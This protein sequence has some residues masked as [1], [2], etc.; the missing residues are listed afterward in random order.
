M[1][2]PQVN[3][4]DVSVTMAT[5]DTTTTPTRVKQRRRS[6]PEEAP[7]QLKFP[8]GLELH[9]NEAT[10][11]RTGVQNTARREARCS[12]QAMAR[13]RRRRCTLPPADSCRHLHQ[14]GKFEWIGD[15]DGGMATLEFSIRPGRP[16]PPPP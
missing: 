3:K 6:W 5:P 1:T 15:K 16:Q 8:R 7:G 10:A 9:V 4:F 13:L 14:V 2:E 12:G 11:T